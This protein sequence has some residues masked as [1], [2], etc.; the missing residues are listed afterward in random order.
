MIGSTRRGT[1]VN[2]FKRKKKSRKWAVAGLAAALLVLVFVGYEHMP[3]EFPNGPQMTGDGATGGGALPESPPPSRVVLL[4]PLS[5]VFAEEGE[6]FRNGTELAWD[7]L[8]KQGVGAELVVHDGAG[9]AAELVDFVR[10]QA[11][12]P[13]TILIVGHEPVE[14]LS[15]ILPICSSHELPVVVPANSHQSLVGQPWVIPLV[16]SDASEGGFA[17]AL[18][19]RWAG[20]KAVAALYEPGTYGEIL[21]GGFREEAEKDGLKFH[22]AACP[23][24]DATALEMALVSVLA[25]EPSVI[26][27]AGAPTWGARVVDLLADKG[28]RG[29]LLAPP[30]Y[31]DVY[32]EDLFGKA[33]DSLYVLRPFSP[34]RT[35]A[36]EAGRFAAS[37]RERFWKEPDQNA[38]AAC[39]AFQ[40][41]G[42]AFRNGQLTRRSMRDYFALYDSPERAHAGIG[43]AVFF[44]SEGRTQ[45]IMRVAAY[46]EGRLQPVDD[47]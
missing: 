29:R 5:G 2:R 9:D 17:A 45:R 30:C 7:E 39:D 41:I 47:P 3:R 27:L 33:L 36:A 4:A 11:E 18:A 37:F 38:V 23:A 6:M 15:A 24:D 28:F 10:K 19:G 20:G 34:P 13:A 21:L 43:G 14:T 16:S 42:E 31:A 25:K 46:R 40:W 12:D 1:R 8:K 32:V 22:E 35:E 44:D 26:W